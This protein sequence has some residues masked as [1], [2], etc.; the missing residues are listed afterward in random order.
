[1]LSW[2]HIPAVFDMS[3]FRRTSSLRNRRRRP[4]CASARKMKSSTCVV[5][6]PSTTAWRIPTAIVT[7]SASCAWNTTPST[8]P[9]WPNAPASG[10][11][12]WRCGRRSRWQGAGCRRQE[13]RSKNQESSTEHPV[14]RITHHEA[15]LIPEAALDALRVPRWRQALL[16]P[17]VQ[18]AMTGEAALVSGTMRFLGVL[19]VDRASASAWATSAWGCFPVSAGCNCAMIFPLEAFWRRQSAA[20]FTYPLQVLARG[21][22]ALASA[23]IHN[24]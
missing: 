16:A 10:G 23:V 22:G 14:T 4:R 1:M 5:T 18:Q 3:A 11:S 20:S 6:T 17:F 9:S 21:V 2:F 15:E 8:G 13:A 19:L 7:S 24:S 12:A